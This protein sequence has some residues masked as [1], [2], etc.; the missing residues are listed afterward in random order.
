MFENLFKSKAPAPDTVWI[1]GRTNG[2]TWDFQ[3][4]FSDEIGAVGACRDADYFVA[5]ALMNESLQ[6]DTERKWPGAYFP[7][8]SKV[9]A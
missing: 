7:L 4:V 6:H 1:C 8:K 2:D 5:P 3:G 9:S